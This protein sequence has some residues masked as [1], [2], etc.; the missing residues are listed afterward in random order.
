MLK[1][2]FAAVVGLTVAALSGSVATGSA[3]VTAPTDVVE[4]LAA[5]A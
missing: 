2:R 5:P 1:L 3:G 4:H